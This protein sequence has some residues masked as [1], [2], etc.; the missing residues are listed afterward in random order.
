[1][2]QHRI[3]I[4]SLFALI[5]LASPISG[6]ANGDES[7]KADKQALEQRIMF[8]LA[9]A[10]SKD[11]GKATP[12]GQAEAAQKAL[13]KSKGKVLKVQRGQAGYT[14]KVLTASGKVQQIWIAD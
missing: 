14:V 4:A 11:D 2:T 9:K 5:G 10:G 8:Q 3:L 13:K 1:M 12:N 7:L 6:A